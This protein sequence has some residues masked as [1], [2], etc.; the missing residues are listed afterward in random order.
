MSE[1]ITKGELP[2]S[3]GTFNPVGHLMLGLPNAQQVDAL[4]AALRTAGWQG[5]ELVNFTPRE[6]IAEFEAMLENASGA[7]GFGYE[8][9]LQRRYLKL[10][11]EGY[12]WLLVKV[13][14]T[15][16]ASHAAEIAQAHGATLAVHY[17]L[18]IVE[19]LI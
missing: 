15:D 3:F 7:A 4:T 2:T 6:S 5:D 12:R 16:E 1:T 14:D 13:D 8:I 11:R 19:E 18:L 17:R 9:T 10:A